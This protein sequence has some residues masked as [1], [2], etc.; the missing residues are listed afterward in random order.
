MR[1]LAAL[2]ITIAAIAVAVV[3]CSSGL[4][5]SATGSV[6]PSGW[7]KPVAGPA[8]ISR[9]A[10]ALTFQ[11]QDTINVTTLV[12]RPFALAGYIDG[13][14]AWR[15]YPIMRARY[16]LAHTLSI[17]VNSSGRANCGDFEPGDMTPAQAPAWFRADKAAGFAKPCLYSSLWEYQHQVIPDMTAAG[18]PT[19][20]YLKWDA[21]YT[22]VPHL[23]AGFQGTQ[24]TDA[25]FGRSLDCSLVT[26]ALLRVATP[27]YV[28][29]VTAVACPAGEVRV[30][31]I[32][33]IVWS[34]N[35]AFDTGFQ[36]GFVV[37]W[38]GSGGRSAPVFT[39]KVPSASQGAFNAGFN[40][41]FQAGWR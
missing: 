32:C 13:H 39:L 29:V 1:K 37:A 9:A 11:M 26:P 7:G 33:Q 10:A 15:T 16:P 41:G 22:G 40:A 27:P 17:A 6:H 4:S 8:G 38:D 19:S 24:Y 23:D 5:S 14:P 31:G 34:Y 2:L 30:H 36:R 3:G 28:P 12:G 18:I 21:D 25:C 35:K 20:A